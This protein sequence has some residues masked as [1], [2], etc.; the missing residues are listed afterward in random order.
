MNTHTT[1]FPIHNTALLHPQEGGVVLTN[2][3]SRYII[4]L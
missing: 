2:P 4:T 1:I 3:G